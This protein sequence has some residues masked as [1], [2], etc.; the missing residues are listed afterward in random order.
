MN[1]KKRFFTL[2]EN[3]LFTKAYQKGITDANRY[4]AVYILRNFKKNPDGTKLPPRMGITV[5]RK[6]GG[7]VKRSRVKRIIREAYR[8]MRP[9]LQKGILIVIAARG[10]AFQKKVKTNDIEYFLKKSLNN[11]GA[12]EGQ[13]LKSRTEKK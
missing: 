5:N 11:L 12:F 9:K 4:T 7:A 2:N 3:H 8:T 6:L 13:T 10:A 1:L